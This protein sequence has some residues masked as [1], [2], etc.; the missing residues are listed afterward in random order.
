M[1]QPAESMMVDDQPT[2]TTTWAWIFL[3]RF[4]KNFLDG[5]TIANRKERLSQFA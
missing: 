5:T 2:R 1:Q 4:V 3:E